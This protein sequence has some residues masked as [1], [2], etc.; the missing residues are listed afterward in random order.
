M[1]REVTTPDLA[2]LAG[3]TRQAAHKLARQFRDGRSRPWQG[4]VLKVREGHGSGGRAGA[5]LFVIVDSLPEL[6]QAAFKARN[7]P[8]QL[9]FP[10]RLDDAA[11]AERRERRAII[12]P[13]IVHPAGS[14]ERRAALR[15]VLATPVIRGGQRVTLP[16]RTVRNWVLAFDTGGDAALQRKER[17][18]KG[19]AAVDV[20]Q[21]WDRLAADLPEATRKEIAAKLDRF[22][23]SRWAEGCSFG[24]VKRLGEERLAKLTREAG[25][26]L[27]ALALAEAC[28]LPK[29]VVERGRSD[30]RKVFL[31]TRDAKGHDDKTPRVR[32]T[33]RGQP[34]MFRV[35]CDA[36]HVDVYLRREDGS[37]ATPKAIAWL[38]AST[39]RLRMDLVLCEP[40]TGLRNA[41]M[42]QS[43]IDMTQDPHWGVAGNVHGDN[44]SEY[45]FLDMLGDPMRLAAIGCSVEPVTRAR[46]YNPAAKGLLEGA[47]RA[48][49]RLLVPMIGSVPGNRI[50]TR[51]ANL[52]KAPQPFDGTFEE[53]T[54]AF[55]GILAFYNSQKQKGDLRGLSP[56]GAYAK[57]VAEGWQRVDVDPDALRT[58]FS[59]KETRTVMRGK[60]S[61]GGELFYC[62]ELFRHDGERVTIQ[63]PKYLKW[64]GIPVFDRRGTFLAVARLD[65]EHERGAASGPIESARRR[66]AAFDTS[67]ELVREVDDE[68]AITLMV[69]SGAAELAPPV[70]ASAGRITVSPEAEAVGKQVKETRRER[71]KRVNQNEQDAQAARLALLEKFGG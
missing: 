48:F 23:V 52:G 31:R 3:I 18:G 62:D 32:Q 42:I 39:H 7:R 19:E 50:L 64:D 53:F 13:I 36:H 38:D 70:P 33:S 54:R 47:F 28:H 34:P 2:R 56:Q 69:A 20:T 14:A 51:S 55:A 49:E 22:T 24:V 25:C 12:A 29:H 68:N 37:L 35:L 10:L 60:I 8:V 61:V 63:R 44:G 71:Q 26:T 41:D 65:E 5:V 21:R 16:E 45:N 43:F 15:A 59:V 57:A 30:G 4:S 66:K 58:A 1:T 40:G 9:A 46:P 17:R 67:A 27:A 6:L 11:S